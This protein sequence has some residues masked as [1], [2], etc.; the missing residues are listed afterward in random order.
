MSDPHPLMNPDRIWGRKVPGYNSFKNTSLVKM[1]CSILSCNGTDMVSE[2]SFQVRVYDIYLYHLQVYLLLLGCVLRRVHPW[3]TWRPGGTR[4]ELPW[5][6]MTHRGHHKREALSRQ[7]TAS[8]E[9]AV[10]GDR[11]LKRHR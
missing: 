4:E 8:L 6:T 11:N 7:Q 9:L 10:R 2:F 3:E 1:R 5:Q